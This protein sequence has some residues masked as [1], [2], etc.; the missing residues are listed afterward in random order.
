MKVYQRRT[1]VK[2]EK[3]PIIDGWYWCPR[4]AVEAR[5]HKEYRRLLKLSSKAPTA[6]IAWSLGYQLYK[7]NKNI[8]FKPA[9]SIQ[10]LAHACDDGEIRAPWV[11]IYRRE[12]GITSIYGKCRTCNTPLSNGIKAIILLG[13]LG[14]LSHSFFSFPSTYLHFV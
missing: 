6:S 7:T 13:W 10:R 5:F 14:S 4:P 8:L 9:T 3:W 12:D 2:R 1:L 11:E